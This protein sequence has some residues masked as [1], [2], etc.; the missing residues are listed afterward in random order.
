MNIKQVGRGG[1]EQLGVYFVVLLFSLLSIIRSITSS[2]NRCANIIVK[3]PRRTWRQKATEMCNLSPMSIDLSGLFDILALFLRSGSSWPSHR[4]CLA[5]PV[6]HQV[7]LQPRTYR[8]T[9]FTARQYSERGPVYAS[10]R[11]SKYS[12]IDFP[13]PTNT[14]TSC[15]SSAVVATYSVNCPTNLLQ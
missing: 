3:S 8:Q 1:L 6:L 5:A 7:H 14:T 12:Q 9:M 4:P 10:S 13:S 15:W 2:R 11:P